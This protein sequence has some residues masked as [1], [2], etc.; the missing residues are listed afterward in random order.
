MFKKIS[1]VA[2]AVKSLDDALVRYTQVL[3]MTVKATEEVPDQKVRI[4]MIPVGESRL[5]LVQG[6]GKDS[7]VSKFV[8]SRGEGIHHIALEVDNIHESL[9]VLKYAGLQLIDEK[10]RVG[11]EGAKIAFVHPKG[12]NGVLLE[13]IEPKKEA[14][15]EQKGAPIIEP[16]MEQKGEPKK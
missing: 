1:H 16:K 5:E 3:G 6:V 9:S 10:P 13:L 8:E 11:A 4:A 12:I 2:I 7:P 15:V 14:K